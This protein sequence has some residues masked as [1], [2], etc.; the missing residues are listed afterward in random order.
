MTQAKLV[1]AQAE[2]DQKK[3]ITAPLVL[4]LLAISVVVPM[5]QY[6]GYT[7]EVRP[8]RTLYLTGRQFPRRGSHSK[9][10]ESTGEHRQRQGPCRIIDMSMP[11][12]RRAESM[13]SQAF[14]FTAGLPRTRSIPD[15]FSEAVVG[16]C[17]TDQVRTWR[18]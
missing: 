15:A 16:F 18:L 4:T 11:N 14:G 12:K 5:L 2:T 3:S 13:M 7:S 8:V 1:R 10:A 17:R 6:W 9:V